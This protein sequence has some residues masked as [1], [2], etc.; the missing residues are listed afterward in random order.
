MRGL[1]EPT[2]LQ[3]VKGQ[4]PIRADGLACEGCLAGFVKP[5]DVL[6]S[7]AGASTK[8]DSSV[9]SERSHFSLRPM[10]AGTVSYSD[11]ISTRNRTTHLFSWSEGR[12]Y[13][14]TASTP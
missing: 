11:G 14:G 9:G 5:S 8:Q 10:S 7:L 2:V 6:S 12:R 1:A 3:S 13:G 4:P